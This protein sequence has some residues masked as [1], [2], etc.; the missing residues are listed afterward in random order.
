MNIAI[1]GE[2]IVSAIG[3]NKQEVL[4]ALQEGRTG[5][6]E[7]KYLQSIHHE[8]PVGEVD[9][10]NEQMKKMLGIPSEQMMSRTSLLGMLAIDQALKE[11]YVNVASL[12]ARKADGKPLRIVLV[13][14]TTVGGL[15]LHRRRRQQRQLL[16]QDILH[17]RPRLPAQQ[18][19][20]HLRAALR[21][22]ASHAGR[23]EARRRADEPCA[24]PCRTARRGLLRREPAQR[25]TLGVGLRRTALLRPAALA[26]RGR[27]AAKQPEQRARERQPR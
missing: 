9:L 2:G 10:S 23:A 24:P 12:R 20:G 26:H 3:L 21:R 1:T 8:L 18:H 22:R 27:R 17:A 6:G 19:T 4:Q 7:M 15:Q 16:P 11:A 25:A 13:S 5:I 14:G